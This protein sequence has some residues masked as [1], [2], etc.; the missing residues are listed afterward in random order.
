[1]Q[2][3]LYNNT[4]RAGKWNA[5]AVYA[6]TTSPI[7]FIFTRCCLFSM[8]YQFMSTIENLLGKIYIEGLMSKSPK[9]CFKL[10]AYMKL[11]KKK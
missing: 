9:N 3:F 5:F 4:I 7:V 2:V 1:M 6:I 8:S 11:K 10:Q